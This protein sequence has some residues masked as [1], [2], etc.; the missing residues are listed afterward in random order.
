VAVDRAVKSAEQFHLEGPLDQWRALRQTMH[1]EI[2]REG[3][4]TRLGCFVQAYGS[5]MVDASLL[6]MP[7]VGFLPATD[8][9]VRATIEQIERSL[10]VDGFVLRYDSEATDD[11]LPAGEGAFLACSFWLTDNYTLMGRRT[12]AM[13]LFGKLTRLANDIGLYAEEYDPDAGRMLGNFPQ[14]FSHVALINT[15]LNLMTNSSKKKR[16]HPRARR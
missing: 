4:N 14:A 12:Q 1:D 15:A 3:F 16:S 13:R 7:Q 5:S 10:L 2:C 11:G 9:R 6:L 8:P